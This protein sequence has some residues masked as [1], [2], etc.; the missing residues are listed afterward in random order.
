MKLTI[1]LS[2]YNGEKYILDQLESL[3][4]QSRPADEVLIFDDGSTDRTVEII[5]EYIQKHCLNGWI[6]TQNELNKGWKKNFIDGMTAAKGDLIFPCD[7]DDIWLPQKLEVMAQIMDSHSEIEVLMSNYLEF[8]SD[9][10]ERMGHPGSGADIVKYLLSS[11]VFSVDYPGCTYCVRKSLFEKALPFWWEGMEHDTLVFQTS[12][13][14]GTLYT[15]SAPLIRW[16][17]HQNSAYMKESRNL[18]SYRVKRQWITDAKKS[19]L[20]LMDFAKSHPEEDLERD[21]FN[22]LQG[23]LEWLNCR[24]RF[25]D[26]KSIVEGIRLWKYRNYFS[27]FRQ[28]PGDWYLVF[29]K[30]R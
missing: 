9:G 23:N 26:R 6:L 14:R 10:Q 2:V 27:R 21:A 20:R 4:A 18:K 29:I 8:Y 7:Q 1:V 12:M 28:Y 19:I 15:Y 13:L 16:R 25:Y 17:K 24:E 3:S 30:N 11:A 22:V 5:R